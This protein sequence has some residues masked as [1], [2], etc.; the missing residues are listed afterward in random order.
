[1]KTIV[2]VVAALA[3][4]LTGCTA[5]VKDRNS[6]SL[7]FRD[8]G[9]NPSARAW[10]IRNDPFVAALARPVRLYPTVYVEDSRVIV[11]QEPV[12]VKMGEGQASLVKI[13]WT[14]GDAGYS[15]PDDNSVVITAVSGPPPINPP[16]CK[17]KGPRPY[18]TIVCRYKRPPGS[19]K[20]VYTITVTDGTYPYHS[21]PYIAND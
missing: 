5:A 8:D 6:E 16:E 15:F 9:V 18:Q 1:M 7:V 3:L 19:A 11:D 14:I 17:T 20:Y 4:L 12:H 10:L 13:E 21:D 2:L